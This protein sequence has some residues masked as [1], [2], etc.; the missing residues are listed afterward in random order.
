MLNLVFFVACLTCS[1]AF[2]R[3]ITLDPGFVPLP[4]GDVEIKE[5]RPDGVSAALSVDRG[6]L[7]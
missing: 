5:V 1:A 2:Y 7:S 6:R 4:S 3:A